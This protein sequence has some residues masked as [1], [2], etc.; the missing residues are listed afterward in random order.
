MNISEKLEELLEIIKTLSAWDVTIIISFFLSTIAPG[1]ALIFIY[2]PDLFEDI[3]SLKLF[4]LS[5]ALTLPIM[6]VN[7]FALIIGCIGLGRKADK[8]T[9]RKHLLFSLNVWTSLAFYCSILIAY[10]C[11]FV[12]TKFLLTLLILD[13]IFGMVVIWIARAFI[14]IFEKA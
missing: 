11:K 13:I 4:A 2:K 3:D 6:S 12:F 10:L 5:A 8:S 9:L 1:L 14:P 7:S